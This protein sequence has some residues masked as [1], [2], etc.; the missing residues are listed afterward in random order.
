V[1]ILKNR[2]FLEA[3][4]LIA[5]YSV[6]GELQHSEARNYETLVTILKQEKYLV[7]QY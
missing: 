7:L 3:A 6:M 5:Y 4:M 1:S 2:Y